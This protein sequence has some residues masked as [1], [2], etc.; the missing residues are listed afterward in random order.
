MHRLVATVALFLASLGSAAQAAPC[1]PACG[2]AECEVEAARCLLDRGEAEPA[3]RRLKEIAGR[4]P[5]RLEVQLLLARA[6]WDL[7]N[8]PWA[9]RVLLG[10]SAARP[11]SCVVRSWLVWLQVKSAELDAAQALLDEPGCPDTDPMRARWELLESALARLRAQPDRASAAL[12]RAERRRV[13][14]EEDRALL[15]DLRSR[16]RPG[17]PAP[18]RL[19]LELGA[20]YTS[21]GL[22]SSPADLVSA[23]RATGSP[24]LLVDAQ[25][26]FEPPWSLRRV[27]PLL[28]LG[29]RGLALT[30]GSVSDYSYYGF[31]LRPG[32]AIGRLRLLYGGQL[33]LL[34]GGDEH[35][36]EGPRW[37]YETHR[38]ELE[39][40]PTSWLTL[41][42]GAGRSI[43]RELART[44]A[45]L[46]G[47]AA[48]SLSLGRARL[49][50]GASLRGHVAQSAAYD[51][52][53][54]MALGSLGLPLGPLSARLRL[55]LSFD[56]YPR[57]A[58]YFT[59]ENRRDLL[60]KAAAE[61]WSPAW[62]GLRGGLTYEVSHRA[63]SVATYEY[64]DHRGLARLSFS[65][66]LDPWA[67]RRAATPRDHVALPYGLTRGQ[68]LEEERIQDLLRQEDAARR[69]SSCVN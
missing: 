64:V 48:F 65:L 54:G 46:D 26:R 7:S 42:G 28:E 21:N 52:F 10:A 18:L 33:L 14:L 9:R 67:P 63:S 19:R 44:R 47:G 36:P 56:I 60:T 20:G 69:G 51:L 45:E 31:S 25:L 27:R 62:R 53:G 13:L 66:E 68:G 34:A 35:Q 15:D 38:G 8:L 17:V 1:A 61:I 58:G 22:M 4:Q 29:V 16:L 40:E 49:L 5:D 41:F 30:A 12:G 23:A 2:T 37:F 3:K 24:A 43:F 11:A 57:S 50:L 59:D 39:W 55:I 6:Y 32:L